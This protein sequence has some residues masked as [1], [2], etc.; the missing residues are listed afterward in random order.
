LNAMVRKKRLFLV[1]GSSFIFRAF[2]ATERQ[3]LTTSKGL[4]T[5]AAYVFT[6]MLQKLEKDMEPDYLVIVW[7]APGKTFREERYEAYKANRAETPSDLIPQFDYIREIVQAFNIASLE[8]EGFEAD[9]VIATIAEK[10]KH[11]KELEIVIVS[12]DKDMGQSVSEN[13]KMYDSMKERETNVDTIRERYGVSP[14]QLIDVFALMGDA[15]D[16][17]PGVMGIGEKTA[18]KLIQDFKSLDTLYQNLDQVP[19][20]I[21]EKL[22]QHK[23]EAYLSR[24]LV[25]LEKKVPVEFKLDDLKIREPNR[26]KLAALFRELEFHKLLNEYSGESA[27]VRREEYQLITGEEELEQLAKE[28]EEKKE[29]AVDIET[30]SAEPMNAAPVGFS[31][32]TD[33]GRAFYVPF[34][35][36][37]MLGRGQQLS[38]RSVFA[39][40]KPIL[41]SGQFKKIG[42]NV[43]YDYTVL[44]RAGIEVKGIAFDTMIASYLLNPR[45]RTHNLEELALEHFGHKMITFEDIAGK[46]KAQKNFSEIDLETACSYSGEDADITFRL[47]KKLSGLLK[48]KRLEKLYYEIELP[49]ALVLARME[50]AGVKIDVKR[51]R[52]LSKEL[53]ARE[54]AIKEA[55]YGIAKG[56]FNIDSPRQLAEVLFS[57]LNLPAKK[58]TKTGYS[59]NIDVLQELSTVHPLPAKIIEYRT[60][61]KMRSTY[62]DA[63]I[64]LLNPNTGRIHTSFNQTITATGRLSSSEPNLQNIPTRTAEG[65]KIREAFIAEKGCRLVAADY[66][67]IELRVLAHFSGEPA[68]IRSFEQ[69]EDIHARTAMEVFGVKPDEVTSEMRR[70]A[71]VINFGI[72]Y[73]MSDFGLAQELKIDQKEAK[74]YIDAYFAR[75]PKVREFLD[76]ILSEAGKNLRI[77]TLMGRQ[78]L[79]PDINSNNQMVRKAA[80]R[81]ATNA[82]MQGSAADIIKAAMIKID[83]K[84]SEQKMKSRMIIQVHDELVFEAPDDEIEELKKLAGREMESAAELK[85]PL[86]VDIEVGDNWAETG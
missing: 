52:E 23:K 31:F 20:K 42:Q 29:F 5:N 16:N 49:L 57:R 63:L 47:Y 54:E 69:G 3:R 51:L 24:E 56:E 77:T 4:P 32:S 21:R 64:E 81:E 68:L 80:E 74:K 35:H 34:G 12:G 79:F 40:L 48:E 50:M 86:K 61:S 1:D 73:G 60:L 46:G 37:V 9:D 84:L 71:K 83:R 30:T 72:L 41:E 25:E 10:L 13:V 76:R 78:C 45:R 39:G 17:I 36:K 66:S 53:G 70:R 19:E 38:K 67:Q 27:E 6:N 33:A 22:D 11:D 58:K 15:I 43:K 82:P 18:V 65:K 59:T 62:T 2:H 7:D 14:E 26:E 44:C 75:Y 28:L 8:K 85:V 55:I